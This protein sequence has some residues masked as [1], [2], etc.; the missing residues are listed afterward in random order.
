MDWVKQSEITNDQLVEAQ[1]YF[2]NYG[3]FS[4]IEHL[5]TKDH[6]DFS[7]EEKKELLNEYYNDKFHR[8]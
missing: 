7:L 4:G 8:M 3:Y 1:Q 6:R 2:L 5:V